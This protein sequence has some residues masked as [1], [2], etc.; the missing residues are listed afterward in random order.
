MFSSVWDAT[1]LFLCGG[2]G[3]GTRICVPLSICAG[4]CMCVSAFAMWG[5]HSFGLTRV[6]LTNGVSQRTGL[7]V[8][9]MR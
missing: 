8:L 1:L 5:G 6:S 4:A 3:T 2:Y 9:L 7:Y